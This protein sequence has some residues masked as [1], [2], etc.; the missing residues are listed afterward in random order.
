MIAF[1]FLGFI[2]LM[3]IGVPIAFS[4]GVVGLLYMVVNGIPFSIATQR[5]FSQTQSFSFLA[6]PFFIFAGNLMV[7]SGISKKI[8]N[9][10]D[11]MVRHLWGGLGCVSVITSMMLAG[12]SGSSVS[13]ASSTGSILIPEMNDK[14]YDPSFSAA[15]NATSSIVGIIIPP[16]N[17]MIIIAYLTNLSVEKMF[18]GGIIPGLMI[19]FSYLY[20]T[21][22]ISKKRHYPREPRATFSEFLAAAKDGIWAALIPVA[23]VGSMITGFATAVEA[24]TVACVLSLLL[25]HFVYHGLTV[26]KVLKALVDAA[27]GT[28]V[29][30]MIVC[31]ASIF[32]Y[33]LIRENVPMAIS[34]MILALN[35]PNWVLMFL[36]IL[37]LSIAGSVMDTIAN[38]FIF[39]PILFPIVEGIGYNS[40][41]FALVMLLCGAISQFT[42]PVGSTL[43]ISCNIAKCTIEEITKD[44]IPFFLVGTAVV[45]LCAFIP[46]LTL[47]I[48][49][50][51]N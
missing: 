12:C 45:V 31:S 27:K 15:I 14:G 44:L 41:Q 49:S 34:T 28:T 48:P 16:S 22:A 30:M 23:L 40:M 6:V 25:G 46:A 17:T 36:I 50:L 8:I 5:F 32:S 4:M 37:I 21:Y 19:G 13:D 26:K 47:W 10:A 20:V 11:V 29:V 7:E 38:L 43:L 3:L 24:S 2:L 1:F 9:F 39:I 35:V 33:V 51:M 18:A 42:P